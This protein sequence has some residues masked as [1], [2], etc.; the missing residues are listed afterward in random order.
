[1][2]ERV[3]LI[4]HPQDGEWVMLR[5][6]GVFNEKTDHVVA[7][8]RDGRIAGGVVFTGYLQ[9]SIVMHMAGVE[10]NWPTRDFLWMVFDYVFVQLGVRKAIGL[11]A[12]SNHRALSIDMRLGFTIEGGIKDAC[13]DGSDLLILTM[14]KAH[15]KWLQLRPVHYRS[16]SVQEAR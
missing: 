8:H 15:C 6:G 10:D 12:S 7:L 1:M 14:D 5:V 2:S 13:P 16:N 4:N 3:I 11:V 9:A